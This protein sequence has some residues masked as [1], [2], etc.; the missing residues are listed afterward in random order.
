MKVCVVTQRK[1]GFALPIPK[2]DIALFGFSA[3]GG[4]DFSEEIDGKS[5]KLQTMAAYSAKCGCGVLCGC[6]TD[7]RGLKRKSV[8]AAS[9]G[10]LLGITDMRYVLDGEEYKSGATVGVYSLHGYRAGVCIDN[11]LLFPEHIKI[12]SSCGCNVVCVHCEDLS[13]SM[14][15]QLIR[16]YAYIY[17]VPIV[18]SAG[19]VAFFADTYGVIASSNRPVSLFETDLKNSYRVVTTRKRGLCDECGS[20]F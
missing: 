19:G 9:E 18:M 7:S 12:L 14:A 11:D 20:D 6:I 13:N 8:A 5:N 1:G 10:K 15:P 17:G 3:L 4:V 16:S 2:C